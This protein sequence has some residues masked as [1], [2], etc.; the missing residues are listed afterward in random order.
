MACQCRIDMGRVEE[1]LR[2]VQRQFDRINDTLEMRR[3]AMQDNIVTNML[4]GYGYVNMLLERDI[5]PL[6]P[7]QLDHF[8]ELNNIVLCGTDPQARFDY[9]GYIEATKRRFYAQD[10]FSI[11]N[12]R[13]WAE[14]HRKDTP[15][16]RAAGVYILQISRPQLFE[17]GNHRSGALLMSCLLVRSGK[18]PFVL[19]VDN[20]KA[21]F[22]P[23]SLAK[24][25]HKT[26]IGMYYKLPKIKKKFSRFLERES[27]KQMLIKS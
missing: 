27:K 6:H 24:E 2:A 8:L 20:A 7:K 19:T 15:W 25:T 12:I 3:E 17:E 11:A 1:S 16:K 26:F 14:K 9:S 5:D 18:P 10:H 13:A 23:S 4:A 21:Y 22:D